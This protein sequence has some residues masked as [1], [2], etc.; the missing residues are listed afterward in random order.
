MRICAPQLCVHWHEALPSTNDEAI[1]LA[2]EGAPEG[3]VVWAERQ[4]AGRGRRGR[5]WDSPPGN[6]YMSVILRPELPLA[7][8]GRLGVTCALVLGGCLRNSVRLAI[9]T[10]WPND[11][12]L[13]GRKVGG[14]LVETRPRPGGALDWAV[15]GLGLN[16]AGHPKIP[17]PGI[18]A[19]SLAAHGGPRAADGLVER[20][21]LAV[22]EAGLIAA[23]PDWEN[24]VRVRW[25][26]SDL[27]SGPIRVHEAGEAFDAEGLGLD[28]DGAL[29]VQVEEEFRRVTAG[30]VSVRPI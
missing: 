13:E 11:L 23:M 26:E 17:P 10:K 29:I 24:W 3:T 9:R 16:V 12:Y 15:V 25:V 14:I 22:L 18:P 21:G 7:L 20:M 30:E 28:H 8:A 27:A 2:K 1:R 19:T 4:T 5:M 6:L